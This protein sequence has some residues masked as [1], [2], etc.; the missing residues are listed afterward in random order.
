MSDWSDP[1]VGTAGRGAGALATLRPAACPARAA[2]R[3]RHTKAARTL[4]RLAAPP[5]AGHPGARGNAGVPPG[6]E[7][8]DEN[9]NDDGTR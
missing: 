7:R 8:T 4:D 3:R 9:D 1:V 2:Q 5:G 6:V